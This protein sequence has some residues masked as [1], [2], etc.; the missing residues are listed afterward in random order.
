MAGSDPWSTPQSQQQTSPWG[1][2]SVSAAPPA[3]GAFD[4]FQS[5][6][7]NGTSNGTGNN[8][9]EAF[10]VLGSRTSPAKAASSTG[11]NLDFFDPL[12]GT[13]PWPRSSPP[14]LFVCVC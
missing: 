3:G 7:T 5:P 2:P 8:I 12:A 13:Q 11:Q 6:A 4:P 1:T 10:D 14:E 9:D